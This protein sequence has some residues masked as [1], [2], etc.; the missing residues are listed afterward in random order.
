MNTHSMAHG[1]RKRGSLLFVFIL[2]LS[3][4][5]LYLY[6]RPQIL[7]LKWP[8]CTAQVRHNCL[9]ATAGTVYARYDYTTQGR[10]SYGSP[11]ATDSALEIALPNNTAD[12]LSMPHESI[13]ALS[14]GAKVTLYSAGRV[15]LYVTGAHGHKYATNSA[16]QLQSRTYLIFAVVTFF[17]ALVYWLV[18]PH[19]PSWLRR[20][21][22]VAAICIGGFFLYKNYTAL[23]QQRQ[24]VKAAARAATET[25]ATTPAPARRTTTAPSGPTISF[26][27]GS[28]APKFSNA[29]SAHAVELSAAL[30]EH[31]RRDR[32]TAW[33][34]RLYPQ[35]TVHGS[36]ALIRSRISSRGLR[37]QVC[38]AIIAVGGGWL[39]AVRVSGP[40]GANWCSR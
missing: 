6:Q 22:M 8:P 2:P 31:Y 11:N 24:A 1:E 40:G 19:L 30:K 25:V 4:G 26:G 21:I 23:I 28:G 37:R 38:R 17:S 18:W 15:P 29:N 14:K 32:H 10:D 39:R 35:V 13:N 34:S 36:D 5:A 16:P 33:L 12:L 3:I 27:H 9:T 20:L 7:E